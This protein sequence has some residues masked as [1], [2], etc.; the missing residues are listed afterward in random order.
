MKEPI[1]NGDVSSGLVYYLK[2]YTTFVITSIECELMNE[3]GDFITGQTI[4]TQCRTHFVIIISL[5]QYNA[6]IQLKYGC[7]ALF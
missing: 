7:F 6:M 2:G 4:H 5:K 1:E 3:N